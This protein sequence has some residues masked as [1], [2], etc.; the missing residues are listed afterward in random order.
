[1]I[2]IKPLE[3]SAKPIFPEGKACWI[4]D[5][6]QSISY[7]LN[8]QQEERGFLRGEDVEVK[9]NAA[10]SLF[11]ERDPLSLKRRF[12]GSFLADVGKK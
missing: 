9:E 12:F 7:T 4:E 10:C 2:L 1:V 3:T 8:Y 5:N 6:A 11:P